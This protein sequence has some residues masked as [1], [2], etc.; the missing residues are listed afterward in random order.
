MVSYVRA[1]DDRVKV[2][3]AERTDRGAVLI[4][5]SFFGFVETGLWTI[6]V[7]AAITVLMRLIEAKKLNP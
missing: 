5:A 6:A 1:K 2:G 3:I 4:L 7:A